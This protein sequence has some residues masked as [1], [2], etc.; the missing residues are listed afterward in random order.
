MK[1]TMN[2]IRSATSTTVKR[3][4]TTST[5]TQQC[6]RPANNACTATRRL[7]KGKK[8]AT[9]GFLLAAPSFLLTPADSMIYDDE[10]DTT[11]TAN[12]LSA[13]APLTSSSLLAST[14]SL[15]DSFDAFL[16]SIEPLIHRRMSVGISVIPHPAKVA[17][18]GEDAYFL[19]TDMKVIGVADG[20]GGW[21]DIGVD[22]ALYS[23]SL[24][25]G[26]KLSAESPLSTRDP[27]EIMSEGYQYSTYVQ[28]SSTCCIIT[29]D[30]NYINA[31][32]LGDSGFMV[33]RGLEIVYRTKEQQHSFNFP[34]QIGTG[35]A[36]KPHHAQRI[37]VEV[38]PDDLI[39]LG[40]DGLWDNLFDEDI[41]DIVANAPSDP[42]TIGQL[43][44]RQAHIVAN[45]KDIISP[46]SK[47]ARS[48]GYPL[49][50]GG[51]LDDITVL[52]ARVVL[53]YVDY[54]ELNN[55][56]GIEPMALAP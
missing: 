18:G 42:A 21:G 37:Q 29:L 3:A 9:G 39:I 32:N 38:Q 28:G 17:K 50:T 56:N 15:K 23:R 14:D 12:N 33:I 43:I 7:S 48:N 22:P 20:V 27:V 51:K 49:A 36:D 1:S 54:G 52:C 47:S 55:N 11:Q 40:T 24:M 13:K 10:A 31:A 53:S 44:A 4:Q 30:G 19:S 5:L 25:E 45:D 46:F 6:R 34:Y 26:S 35:S 41:I 8:L 16:H 2:I